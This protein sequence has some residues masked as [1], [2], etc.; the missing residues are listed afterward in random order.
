MLFIYCIYTDTYVMLTYYCH[1]D[2][3]SQAIARPIYLLKTIQFESNF[4]MI[5]INNY[6]KNSNT[7]DGTLYTKLELVLFAT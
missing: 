6:K 3:H 2:C 5:A 4:R 1:Y 7:G